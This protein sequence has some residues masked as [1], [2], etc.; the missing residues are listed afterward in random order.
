MQQACAMRYIAMRSM[1]ARGRAGRAHVG[2]KASR[3]WSTMPAKRRVG[4]DEA[5]RAARRT[6]RII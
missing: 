3:L 6:W 2:R 1:H 5:I 4:F